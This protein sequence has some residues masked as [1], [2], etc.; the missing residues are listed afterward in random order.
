MSKAKKPVDQA[1]TVLCSYLA[2]LKSNSKN[3]E[4]ATSA[5]RYLSADEEMSFLQIVCGLGCCAK[6]VTKQ[7]A[8]AMI[9][10]NVNENV[11]KQVQVQCSEKVFRKM[12]EKH[13]DASK[14]YFCWIVR[15]CAREESNSGNKRCSFLQA[16]CLHKKLV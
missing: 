14:T 6:G 3:T 13:P 4:G 11:D 8:M 7:E 5:N 9:D 1:K 16:R 12:M 2:T 10:D 15:S